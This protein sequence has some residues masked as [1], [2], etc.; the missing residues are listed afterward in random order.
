MK[1]YFRN[2]FFKIKLI[3]LKNEFNELKSNRFYKIMVKIL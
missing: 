2:K 3:I 1:E